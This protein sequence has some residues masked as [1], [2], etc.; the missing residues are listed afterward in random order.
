MATQSIKIQFLCDSAEPLIFPAQVP[1]SLIHKAN[2]SAN[3]PGFT[4]Q[5]MSTIMPLLHVDDPMVAVMVC[6]V[7]AK[8]D[9]ELSARQQVQKMMGEMGVDRGEGEGAIREIMRCAVCKKTEGTFKCSRCKVT[10]YCGRE[11]QKVDWKVHKKVCR[12][13]GLR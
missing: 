3:D 6:P 11:H 4:A 12:E 1:R 9:C 2:A 7:C 13:A 5:F 10:F 8:P